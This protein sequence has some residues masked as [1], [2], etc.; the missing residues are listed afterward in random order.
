MGKTILTALAL[1]VALSCAY[2]LQTSF[3]DMADKLRRIDAQR[4]VQ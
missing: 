3:E 4:N 2:A 1:V